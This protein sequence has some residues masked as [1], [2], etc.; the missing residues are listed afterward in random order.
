MFEIK[1]EEN[2]ISVKVSLQKRTLAKHP[3]VFIYSR[4]ALAKAKETFPELNISDKAD[5]SQVASTVR[6]PH[7]VVW[8]F[9]IIE[10]KE[11]QKTIKH[12]KTIKKEQLD[13][14]AELTRPSEEF[15]GYD[16]EFSA[17]LTSSESSATMEE[18]VEKVQEPTE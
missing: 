8:K 9:K 1:R 11:E 4:D 16:K 13:T 17:D 12:K 3:K 18:T 7:E 2:Y 14:L 10:Q 6:S 5:N 15:S